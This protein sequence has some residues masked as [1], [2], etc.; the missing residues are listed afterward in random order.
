[1]SLCVFDNT[2]ISLKH[3]GADGALIQA[4]SHDCMKYLAELADPADMLKDSLLI[5]QKELW[6]KMTDANEMVNL[7]DG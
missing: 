4:N 2:S 7:F 6:W 3:H 5:D 1:M